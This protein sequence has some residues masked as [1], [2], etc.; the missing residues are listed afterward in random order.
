M[1]AFPAVSTPP[2]LLSQEQAALLER[3]THGLDGAGLW[4][5]SG[6]AAGLARAQGLPAGP[7]TPPAVG[8][9]AT[10]SPLTIVY[11][12]QT[13]NARRVAEALAQQLETAGLPTRL[14]RADAYATRHLKDERHIAV[15]ISTQ[16]D[17]EPPDDARA[18]VEFLL[19]KRAPRVPDLR[20]AVFGL[21]DSSYP[22]FCAIGR[23]LDARLESLGATRWL[24]RV[25]ADL[26]VETASVPWLASV[27]DA[28]RESLR[29]Q[30]PMATVTPLRP[31]ASAAPVHTREQPF[32][33]EVLV[34]QRITGRSSD[35]DVRHVEISLEGS[36][37]S[38]EPGDALGVWPVNPP[39]LVDAL[40]AATDIDGALEVTLDG[41][42]RT[43]REWLAQHR[44]ITRLSR[45]FLARLAALGRHEAL[46]ALLAPDRTAE[47]AQ[48][49]ARD[50]VLDALRAHPAPWTGEELV[51][52]LRPLAP[53][54]YSIA[55]SQK[56][57]GDEV[58]LTVA[59]V[60]YSVDGSGATDS[61][62]WGAASDH[63]AR[64]AEGQR[65]R[66][67]IEHNE[68]F[69]L[70]RDG[71]RD[72]IMIGPGTGV[73]PF[74]GFVQD[75][76]SDA[77][78]GRQWLLFGNPHARSDFLY[79]LEWQRA[80]E[81]GEL[82]HLDLAF[83]RDQ[84]HKV[85]V[86]DRLREHGAR[87][88]AWLAGGAHLYVCGDATRMARDVHATLIEILAEHGGVS[89]AQAQEQLNDLQAQGRYAR[90]VY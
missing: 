38:Y 75:R 23:Q 87:L 71:S 17:G 30:A 40:L 59:H 83:S 84:T 76:A 22:Q 19:G 14:V 51:A 62:R 88:H 33:A 82:H 39:R 5:L 16:G 80:L 26:D 2:S 54:L 86:Q 58:H 53:R 21:G 43:L 32:L 8:D 41:R 73:A 67:F 64:V 34:N 10:A 13:G 6:Y 25:D 57:V 46:N 1:S 49:F 11:G 56:V 55:S 3:L 66:V 18:F 31:L 69:R 20:F 70:P 35:R 44:E 48:V 29:P 61:L 50:Q 65:I 81:R 15:V 24:P 47:L 89:T 77:A 79:Q 12:S 45:P 27:L 63:L 42:T 68:R 36:G 4:W 52:A 90:D 60:E 78:G 85:Y 28:A 9:V 72:V 7:G 37:L 74:R